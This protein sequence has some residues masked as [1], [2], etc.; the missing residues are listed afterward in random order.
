MA[1]IK[2][3]QDFKEF[4]SLLNSAKIEYLPGGRYSEV[5]PSFSDSERV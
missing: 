5:S 3:M 4:L 2:W 1:K